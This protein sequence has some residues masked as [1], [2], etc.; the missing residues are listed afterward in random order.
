M[1]PVFLSMFQKGF[2]MDSSDYKSIVFNGGI[3][4]KHIIIMVNVSMDPQSS[5]KYALPG[6]RYIF[7]IRTKMFDVSYYVDSIV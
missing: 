3:L 5:S 2:I 7:I 1:D 6:P 4:C